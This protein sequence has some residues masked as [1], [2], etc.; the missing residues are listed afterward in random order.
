[1]KE[2]KI[3]SITSRFRKNEPALK[4]RTRETAEMEPK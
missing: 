1:M 3:G 2:W 4:D